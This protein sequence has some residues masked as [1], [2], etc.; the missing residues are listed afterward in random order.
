MGLRFALY[1]TLESTLS[2]ESARSGQ[3]RAI[4]QLARLPWW[5]LIILLLGITLLWKITT[6]QQYSVIL[7]RLVD[8]IFITVVV[9][10]VAFSLALVIGLIAGLG[11]VS[12]NV[13]SY[14][15]STLYVQL[16][17]GIPILVQLLFFAFVIFPLFIGFLNW[18]G[19]LIAPL[20][21]PNNFLAGIQVN[22]V[23]FTTRVILALAF[24]YG[25]FE[26]ETFRAGIQS[27]G[28]GQMEAA[29]S[30]GMS[31]AQAMIFVILPQAIR[32]VLPPLG[33]DFISMVKDSSLVSVLGV[34]DVT[35]DARLYAAASFRYLET[36]STLAFVYLSLTVSLSLLLR[37][38]EKRL[39]GVE[40]GA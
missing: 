33:N 35:Q 18:I 16:I 37:L 28:K 4:D 5:L 7:G 13:F 24:A 26:A 20:F 2:L 36:Y 21:G 30:L 25:G 34:R 23:D 9:A 19:N 15:I 27:V 39:G 11:R 1:L 10:V 38:F 31:Y 29:R 6:D 40:R 3:G 32:R 12:Q 14:N 17:R 8:G 22:N